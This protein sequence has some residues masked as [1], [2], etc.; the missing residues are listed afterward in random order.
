MKDIFFKKYKLINLA[1]FIIVSI[2]TAV[3]YLYVNQGNC[4]D[5][6]SLELKKGILNPLFTGGKLLLI[7]LGILLFFPTHIFR[8]WLFY[9]APP[10]ILLTFY[11]VQGISVYS[12]NLLNPT[13]GKMAENGMIILAVVT[14][15]FIVTQL[16]L[17]WKRR[18]KQIS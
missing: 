12:G 13:R 17:D 11:L 10:V 15:M 4:I 3:I 14:M 18:I 1:F 5:N 9:I 6:C 16:F 8:K 2:I 7:I